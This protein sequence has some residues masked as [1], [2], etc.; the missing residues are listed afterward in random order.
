MCCQAIIS[1][2]LFKCFSLMDPKKLHKMHLVQVATSPLGALGCG[3]GWPGASRGRGMR[4]FLQRH[5]PSWEQWASS[6]RGTCEMG[7]LCL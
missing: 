2:I 4:F 5:L 1:N 7:E 6:A 3:D